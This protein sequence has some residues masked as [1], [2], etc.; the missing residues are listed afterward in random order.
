MSSDGP[1]PPPGAPLV[2]VLVAARDA[3]STLGLA[4]RSILDQSLT[5]LELI[6]VDDHSSDR[7][8]EIVAAVDDPRL[9]VLTNDEH[10]GLAASLNIGLDHARGRYVARLDA[11]DVAMRERLEVQVAAIRARP[12]LAVLGSAVLEID[13]HG[14]P[15][16]RHA[17]PIGSAAVHWQAL[18]GAP[19]YHPTVLL[20]REEL[21]RRALRYD[22]SF[23]V[24][25]DYDL[26]VRLLGWADGDN[27]ADA[28]VLR[29]VHHGQSS[30]R[31]AA[32]QRQLQLDVAR[33]AIAEIAPELS[34]DEAERAW[35]LGFGEPIV[36]RREEA[37][38]AFLALLDAFG[39]RHGS[40]AVRTIAARRLAR[41]GALGAA[42]RVDPLLVPRFAVGRARARRLERRDA[43]S[44]TAR[45]ADLA[46]PAGSPTRVVLVSP[47][48]TPYRAPLLDR[49]SA[50][51]E[52][53]LTVA[54]AAR[55]VARRGWEVPVAHRA[56]VLRGLRLPG[57]RRLL[58][59]D[60]PVTPGIWRLLRTERPEVVVATGWST[61]ASQ[62]AIV[63][64]RRRHVPYLLLVS[65]HDDDP[66]P[67]WRRAVKGAVVPRLVRGASGALALGTRSRASLV[68]RGA[69]PERIRVFANTV[70]VAA[71]V[72][73]ADSLA[74]R[75]D[76]LRATLGA[77]A[78]DVVV[79]SVARL[80]PE[81]G[82]STLVHAAAAAGVPELLLVVAGE[83]PERERL[84][85][86]AREAGV[87]LVLLGHV[88]PERLPE[89][90]VAA[91]VF[92]LLSTSEPWGVVANEAMASGLPLVLSESVGAA[93]DLLENGENGLLVPAGDAEAAA[94][95]LARLA[96]DPSLREAMARRSRELIGR[97]DYDS[98]VQA[99]VDAVREAAAR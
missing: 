24:S 17:A 76:A 80:A 95:A 62:A 54:Y 30:K 50:R 73:R 26:W 74:G 55:T 63:W 56:I 8:A 87:R 57:V 39:R 48:P 44:A 18:F 6:V 29:R 79:L 82:L 89:V 69:V 32:L 93:P 91:D 98:S 31:R 59:H 5:D 78:G 4:V 36:A 37:V 94:R 38:A 97:F 34:L 16:A 99:F 65:S 45:L 71:W 96:A 3:E 1:T 83:G 14:R 61:F 2:S 11:D 92:A 9:V 33:R 13:E 7:T 75:R 23:A 88:A 40:G 86:E 52:V 25:Q 81:K 28:L 22:E 19:F 72:A 15:G 35:Q 70:D 20:D 51:P 42:L 85:E 41:G 43:A 67:G 49:V 66:R 47:E 60:Y 53:D 12:G 58:R 77:D 90:Y 10:R 64:A 27:L 21:E 84:P 68:A 46:A